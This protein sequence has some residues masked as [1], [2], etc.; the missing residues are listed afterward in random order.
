MFEVSY[1]NRV[2]GQ[3]FPLAFLSGLPNLDCLVLHKQLTKLLMCHSRL[4]ESTLQ[5]W[6][7]LVKP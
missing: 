2:D 7:G 3:P 6:Y 4:N 1:Y 5:R